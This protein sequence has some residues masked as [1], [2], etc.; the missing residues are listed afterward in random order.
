V[1]TNNEF[2]IDRNVVTTDTY[3]TMQTYDI[4]G[5]TTTATPEPSSLELAGIVLAVL[6]LAGIRK[7][8]A[9]MR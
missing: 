3:L 6:V 7:R 4:L 9:Q 5:T 2:A 1:N 8:F